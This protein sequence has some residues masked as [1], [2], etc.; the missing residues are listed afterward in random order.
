MSIPGPSN[1][2]RTVLPNGITLLIYENPYAQSVSFN[3]YLPCGAFLDPK[4]KSGLSY[5]TSNCLHT[6]TRFRDFN[7]INDLQE[8]IGAS[9]SFSSGTHTIGVH[10]RSLSEDLP[11]MFTLL[12]E[13]LSDAV[14]P[15]QFIELKRQQLLTGWQMRLHD[16][17]SMS[18]LV[19][20]ETIYGENPYARS[21]EGTPETIPFITREDV[22]QFK[23][24]H[25]GPKGMVLCIAGG[26]NAV[27]TASL[28]E[29]ILGG[30]EKAQ[31]SIDEASFF[32]KVSF[33]ETAIRKHY[34]IP[35]KMEMNLIIGTLGPARNDP[36]YNA[37]RIGNSVLGEFG[38]M[39]RIGN[40]VREENGLAYY[41]GSQL[42]SEKMSGT[43]AAEAG[44]NIENT[45]KALELIRGEFKRFVDSGV[46]D[47]ELS[48]VKSFIQGSRPMTYEGNVK[49]A[50]ILKE[51]AFYDL[52]LDYCE[53]LTER[54][55]AVT[56]EDILRV[57]RKWLDPDRLLTVT[58][59]TKQ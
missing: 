9:L 22:L 38:M 14:F 42:D 13:T 39:G 49:L 34:E 56:K 51:M 37:A 32:P 40:I 20:D 46:T 8:R 18:G 44:V 28:A 52:G 15:E 7:E 58:A 24:D 48:D 33:P 26:I 35:D 30:W 50:F 27:Q 3:G 43:W 53:K 17:E 23:E 36:D 45:E 1:I 29:E 4:G 41:A 57:A 5:L 16:T 55:N 11:M 21:T 59:G 2:L 10:G 47:E 31:K 54:I 25:I 19:F 12:K 6:G